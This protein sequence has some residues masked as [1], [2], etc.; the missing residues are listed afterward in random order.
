EGGEQLQDPPALVAAERAMKMRAG[1]LVDE[2]AVTLAIVSG[3][4]PVECFRF[5]ADEN[6]GPL[7][8]TELERRGFKRRRLRVGLDR[9]LAVVKILELPRSESAALSQM[10]RFELGRHV[11]FP[12]DESGCR[13]SLEPDPRAG[14]RPPPR[15]R[16][17]LRASAP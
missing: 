1:I 17:R 8:A 10:V 12:P 7:I 6:A 11:P 9:S 16:C 15:A 3:R 14:E 2:T 5:D 13:W 4:G